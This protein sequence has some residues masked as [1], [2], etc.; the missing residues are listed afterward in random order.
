MACLHRFLCQL[1]RPESEAR[2]AVGST[3]KPV[4]LLHAYTQLGS[5]MPKAR[6]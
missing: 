2:T 3:A 1:A 4:R 6:W 5:A